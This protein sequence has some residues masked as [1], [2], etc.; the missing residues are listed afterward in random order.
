MTYRWAPKI[1]PKER[2]RKNGRLSA[3]MLY[4]EGF[5]A[6]LEYLILAGDL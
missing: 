1:I 4:Q 3:T 5:N 2:F 6:Y